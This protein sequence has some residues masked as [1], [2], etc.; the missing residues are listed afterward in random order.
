[1]PDFESTSARSLVIYTCLTLI[2]FAACFETRAYSDDLIVN[3]CFELPD[4]PSG[5]IVNNTAF[6][7]GWT[8]SSVDHLDFLGNCDE[9]SVDLVGSPNLGFIEQDVPTSKGQTYQLE[10][11]VR[12][13]PSA[14]FLQDSVLVRWNGDQ[15]F[16]LILM[17]S[18]KNSSCANCTGASIDDSFSRNSS[19]TEFSGLF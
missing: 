2:V 3:G 12:S 19:R 11:F 16:N 6:L 13:A 5:E 1:M 8:T 9:Q 7:P 18:T 14:G 10:F 15:W 4:I 17:S